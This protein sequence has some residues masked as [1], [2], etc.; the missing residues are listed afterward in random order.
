MRV[1]GRAC[2]LE[3]CEGRGRY[4]ESDDANFG[5]ERRELGEEELRQA[6]N[7][8]QSRVVA[9]VHLYHFPLF[10]IYLR[11]ARHDTHHIAPPHTRE[12]VVGNGPR[13]VRVSVQ[14]SFAAG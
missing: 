9:C 14:A 6:E 11:I 3:S 12:C 2:G 4:L 13:T 5:L 10:Q 7:V 8:L 1:C